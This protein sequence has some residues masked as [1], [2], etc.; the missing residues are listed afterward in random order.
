MNKKMLFLIM[1]A[2]ITW[3]FILLLCHDAIYEQKA[4]QPL[5]KSNGSEQSDNIQELISVYDHLS[6]KVEHMPLEEYI[7]HVLSAEMPSSYGLE[8]LKAQ[9]VAA[10][11]YT[12][13][14]TKERKNDHESEADVC[15][16]YRHCQAYK[17]EEEIISAFSPTQ[18][19][20]IKQAVQET[21]GEVLTYEGEII[22]AVYHASSDKSTE[23]AQ[24]VWGSHVPYLVSVPSENE[25]GMPGFES[26]VFGVHKD[27]GIKCLSFCLFKLDIQ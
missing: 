3:N 26:E 15:S 11:T 5:I 9:A 22:N 14:C 2:V 8:A 16:D 4:T 27:A 17:R 18:L 24:N 7:V 21:A 23:S 19:S 6:C 10:R 20:L 25:S 12:L 1:F 13:Y